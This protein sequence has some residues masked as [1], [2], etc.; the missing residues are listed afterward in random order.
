MATLLRSLKINDSCATDNSTANSLKKN[1][2]VRKRLKGCRKED[3]DKASE[4][5][6]SCSYLDFWLKKLSH[7]KFLNHRTASTELHPLVKNYG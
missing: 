6:K 1:E 2:I 4:R 7:Q 3:N 5:R